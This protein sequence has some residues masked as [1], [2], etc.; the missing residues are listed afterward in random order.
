MVT[1][2]IFHKSVN[3]KVRETIDINKNASYT[4]QFLSNIFVY[5]SNFKRLSDLS[6]PK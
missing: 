6:V 2:Y 1:T 3:L 4:D 5:L